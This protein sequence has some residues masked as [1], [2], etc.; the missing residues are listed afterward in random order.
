MIAQIRGLRLTVLLLPLAVA[1]IALACRYTVR[2]IGFV[3]LS[4]PSARLVLVGGT[5]DVEDVRMAMGDLPLKVETVDPD[6]EPTHPAVIAARSSGRD[7]ILLDGEGRVLAIADPMTVGHTPLARELAQ[8]APRTFAFVILL[9]SGDT[10]PDEIARKEV[11]SLQ[12]SLEASE[13]HLPRPLGH[14]LRLSQLDPEEQVR[15]KALLW[16]L[17]VDLPVAEPTVLIVYGRARRAGAAAS[18]SLRLGARAGAGCMRG[19]PT[20]GS[21]RLGG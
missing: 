18:R 6:H 1:S 5:T 16:S 7:A 11:E 14:P 9:E 2:D 12:T 4:D 17:G 15:E 10:A 19:G 13:A 21:T 20:R 8:D 3:R